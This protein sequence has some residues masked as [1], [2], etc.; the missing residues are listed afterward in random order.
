MDGAAPLGIQITPQDRF[1]HIAG[2]A[3]PENG[4]E[5]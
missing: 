3:R 1:L 4:P 5:W 2:T